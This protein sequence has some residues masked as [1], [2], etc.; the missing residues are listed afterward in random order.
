MADSLSYY[1]A[2]TG[3]PSLELLYAAIQCQT[4]DDGMELK[5]TKFAF[6]SGIGFPSRTNPV[7]KLDEALTSVATVLACSSSPFDCP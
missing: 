7:Q 2:I 4:W 6:S 1:T 5:S 3:M